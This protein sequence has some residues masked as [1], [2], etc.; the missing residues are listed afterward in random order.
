MILE[1]QKI[2]NLL[3]NTPNKLSKFRAKNCIEM[4]NQSRLVYNT[5]SDIKFKTFHSVFEKI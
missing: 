2:R 3:E 1:Y 5:N 4:N